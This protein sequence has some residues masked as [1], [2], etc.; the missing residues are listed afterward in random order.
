MT[1]QISTTQRMIQDAMIAADRRGEREMTTVTIHLLNQR[2][3][4]YFQ[5]TYVS[6]HRTSDDGDAIG[7]AIKKHF[8]RTCFFQRDSGLP[9][10]YYGQI[11]R[12][13]TRSGETF[14]ASSV[15]GRVR[16]D[17]ER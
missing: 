7:R 14:S 8:G 5:D 9:V 12:T 1:A 2:D 3:H 16:I 4:R 15:T 10:G 13:V 6:T 17:V 11:F